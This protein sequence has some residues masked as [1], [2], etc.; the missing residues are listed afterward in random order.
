MGG[1]PYVHSFLWF[2]KQPALPELTIGFIIEA[3]NCA[4]CAN[5]PCKEQDLGLLNLVKTCKI[6]SHPR[7]YRKKAVFI[8]IVFILRK[9]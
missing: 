3:P 9:R 4:A 1:C 5:V 2:L 6:H 8:M 7:D